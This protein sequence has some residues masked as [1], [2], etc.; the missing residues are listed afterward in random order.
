MKKD[1]GRLVELHNQELYKEQ[2]YVEI[3]DEKTVLSCDDIWNCGCVTVAKFTLITNLMYRTDINPIEQTS[4][5]DAS[6][7]KMKIIATIS[8]ETIFLG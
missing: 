7:V 6:L 5:L 1:S 3:E 8:V 2:F 4:Q